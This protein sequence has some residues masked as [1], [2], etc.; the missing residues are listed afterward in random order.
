MSKEEKIYKN[1]HLLLKMFKNRPYHLAKYL[2]DN[3]ALT[4]NFLLKVENS[5]KL[6]ELESDD[7]KNSQIYLPTISKMEEY[8]NSFID[9]EIKSKT[10]E[11]IT[12]YLNI[13]LVEYIKNEK[14][15]DAAR[16]RDYMIRKGIKKNQFIKLLTLN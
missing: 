12:E 6:K 13:K 11:E 8:Y 3:D 10:L 16:I 2:L 14:Y 5:D 7:Q 9:T 1:L 4:K 15:E